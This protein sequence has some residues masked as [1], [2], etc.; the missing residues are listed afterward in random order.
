MPRIVFLIIASKEKPWKNILKYGPRA[1]WYQDLNDTTKV[2]E[3]YSDGSGGTSAIDKKDPKRVILY[4]GDNSSLAISEPS[5]KSENTLT[6]KTV[7]GWGELLPVTFSA[8]SYLLK[9]EDFDYVVRTNVS[10][11][12]NVPLVRKYLEE[13]QTESLYAGVIG[14]VEDGSKVIKYAS[15]AGI[16]MSKDIARTLVSNYSKLDFNLIDDVAIGKL[17]EEL[18]IKLT[19]LQRLDVGR[20][21]SLLKN[22]I[23][24]Q[25]FYHFRLKS[26]FYYHGLRF[27]KDIILMN[28]L[29]RK[30]K[31]S[32]Y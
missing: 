18:D 15:G 27:R 2:F 12:W 5:Y 17:A 26:E 23:K 8:L 29:H 20:I 16:V 1:T 25:D 11:Y 31:K 7:S 21:L 19:A 6:F 28:L 4:P 3:V 9:H 24:S 32:R 22:Q 13:N 14:T 10:S 30:V